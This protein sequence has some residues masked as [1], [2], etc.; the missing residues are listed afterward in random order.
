MSKSSNQEESKEKVNIVDYISCINSEKVS[1]L[2][3]PTKKAI[4]RLFSLLAPISFL[5][6][7]LQLHDSSWLEE[8]EEQVLRRRAELQELE[9]ELRGREEAL[10]HREACLQQK[11]QLETKMLRSSQVSIYV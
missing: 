2:V 11:N 4:L 6:V 1:L 5:L 8:E 10:L 3:I 7:P 9:E